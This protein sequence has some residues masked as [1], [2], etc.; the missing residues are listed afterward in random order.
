MAN[1]SYQS[2][3]TCLTAIYRTKNDGKER[4]INESLHFGV[5]TKKYAYVKD[6]EQAGIKTFEKS[7]NPLFGELS[8]PNVKKLLEYL[9]KKDGYLSQ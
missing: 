8:K 7:K 1:K 4:V 6:I 2:V 3:G 9:L 5:G